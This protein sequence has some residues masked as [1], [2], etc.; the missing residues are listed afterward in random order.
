MSITKFTKNEIVRMYMHEGYTQESISKELGVSVKTISATL[1]M[2]TNSLDRNK[3]RYRNQ[4][5]AVLLT[6]ENKRK[7]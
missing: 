5:R 6:N 3:I 1:K 7:A 4:Q 2:K